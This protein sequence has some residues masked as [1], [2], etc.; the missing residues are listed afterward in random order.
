MKLL[1][2]LSENGEMTLTQLA[3]YADSLPTTVIRNLQILN[4]GKIIYVSRQEGQQIFYRL[5]K[6][7]LKR[8]K[9]NF[10]LFWDN[11]LD[12]GGT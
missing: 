5:N 3:Q 9:I 8:I 4:E 1:E 6:E 11:I 12:E 2:G 10:D 7:L